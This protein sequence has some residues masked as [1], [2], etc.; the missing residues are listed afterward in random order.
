MADEPKKK[1]RVLDTLAH[2]GE[3]YGPAIKGKAT[4]EMTETQAGALPEGVVEL[5]KKAETEKPA[6]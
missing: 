3:V 1:Y 4:V 2:D 5:I 6:A